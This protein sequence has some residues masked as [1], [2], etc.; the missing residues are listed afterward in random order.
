MAV[1]RVERGQRITAE[2]FN[3]LV[4]EINRLRSELDRLAG[5]PEDRRE[6]LLL[7]R[8]IA[9]RP[10]LHERSGLAMPGTR[11]DVLPIG[12]GDEA[13]LT[14]V[15]PVLRPVKDGSAG[16]RPAAVGDW[17]L[18]LRLPAGDGTLQTCVIVSEPMS[19]GQCG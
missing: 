5:G 14:D 3:A 19:F 8:I 4:D 15:E 7:G 17:A 6:P 2:A 10:V 13:V 9:A 16:F 12:R 18:V 1:R 11:Y